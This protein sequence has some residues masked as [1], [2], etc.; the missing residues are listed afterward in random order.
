M[1]VIPGFDKT[2]KTLLP[3]MLLVM[4]FF[5]LFNLG[6]KIMMAIGLS[7]FTASEE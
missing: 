4:C 6:S 2:F 1:D 3:L 5:N 7:D